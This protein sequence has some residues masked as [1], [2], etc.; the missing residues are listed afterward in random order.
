MLGAQVYLAGRR[1]CR[2]PSR[3]QDTKSA[4]EP[5]F[6]AIPRAPILPPALL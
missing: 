2:M 5:Q 1:I 4:E 3:L 6:G